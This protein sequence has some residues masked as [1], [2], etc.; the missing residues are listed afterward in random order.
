MP[1]LRTEA[2]T[3]GDR[4]ADRKKMNRWGEGDEEAR[5]GRWQR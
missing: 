3:G 5:R 4:D 1:P 2:T